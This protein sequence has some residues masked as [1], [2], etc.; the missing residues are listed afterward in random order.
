TVGFG[1]F[2]HERCRSCDLANSCSFRNNGPPA[3]LSS[4]LTGEISMTSAR[5]FEANRR[6]AA[7]STG[8]RTKAG[9]LRSSHNAFKHGLAIGSHAN[10]RALPA[11]EMLAR[12]I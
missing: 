3:G 11:V 7:L 4:E 2:R 9:K 5:Q 6:N 12:A 1:R 10:A 8:P